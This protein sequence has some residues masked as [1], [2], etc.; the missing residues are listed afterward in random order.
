M[1]NAQRLYEAGHITYMRTDSVNLSKQALNEARE[2]ITNSYGPNFA[3]TRVFKT[4]NK[5]AQEAHEAIRPTKLA[6]NAC[7][8]CT[9]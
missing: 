1:S 6:N 3:Q 5:G 8:C 9:R 2:V 7:R 4:K